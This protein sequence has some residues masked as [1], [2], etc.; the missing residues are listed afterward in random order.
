MSRA[1]GWLALGILAAIA[2]NTAVDGTEQ[3]V[4]QVA[5]VIGFV[6]GI[7]TAWWEKP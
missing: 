1:Q 2:S 4:W 5:A 3:F 6:A 7:I